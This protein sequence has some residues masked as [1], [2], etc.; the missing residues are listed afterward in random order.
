MHPRTVDVNFET[1]P[2]CL[3]LELAGESITAPQTI[4]SWDNWGI[5]VTA[6]DQRDGAGSAWV[7]DGWS[8]GGERTHTITT[9]S[10]AAT[11]TAT[12]TRPVYPRPGGGTPLSVPLAPAFRECTSAAQDSNHISPLASD[13]CSDPELESTVLSTSSTGAAGGRF[14]L[15]VLPGLVSTPEDE[16]DV[17]IAAFASDVRAATTGDDYS[18]NVI[19]AAGLRLT[20]GANGSYGLAPGTVE[21]FR[22]DVPIL[23]A[24]TPASTAGSDCNSTTSADTLVPG[25]VEESRRSILST[26]SVEVLD[27]GPDESITPGS[28]P[29][30]L[31][32]PPTCG[33]GDEVPFLRQAIFAP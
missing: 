9:P 12:F 28:D 17:R 32:C 13:S 25:L 18:G 6:P 27:A 11:Y 23:C 19:L 22:L 3:R 8:D 10:S 20:D 14:H 2:C 31:G 1:N 24:A 15:D 16:A 5:S 33:S 21:D 7:F 29:L 30:G 26:L 4:T